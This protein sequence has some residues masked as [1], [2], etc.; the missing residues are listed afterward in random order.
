MIDLKFGSGFSMLWCDNCRAET[1]HYKS[2][3]ACG[4]MFTPQIHVDKPP[5]FLAGKNAKAMPRRKA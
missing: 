5:A 4:A 3:C 1:R 2:R